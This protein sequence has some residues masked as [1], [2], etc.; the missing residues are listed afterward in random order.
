M[1]ARIFPAGRLVTFSKNGYSDS[2]TERRTT[3]LHDGSPPGQ[4]WH[5]IQLFDDTDSLANAV[6]AFVQ[7]GVSKRDR[8]LVVMRPELW[9]LTAARLDRNRVSIRNAIGSD[10]LSVL[11]SENTLRQFMD[12]GLPEPRLFDD[13]VGATVRNLASAGRAVRVYG[14]MVDVL[15]SQ[16]ELAAATRL[17]ELWNGLGERLSFTLY[18]GYFGV[19]FA[20]PR[21]A[22]GLRQICN[23]HHAAHADAGD[24]LSRSLLEAAEADRSI[25]NP[26]P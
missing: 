21:A 6:A 15:A 4:S 16:G 23:L 12:D 25:A 5:S 10:H 26:S 13:V 18:C 19:N 11:D 9:N 14:D 24:S 1:P 22:R 7:D 2:P 17:E 8:V 20:D 3:M